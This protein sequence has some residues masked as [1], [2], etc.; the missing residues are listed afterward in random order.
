MQQ[1]RREVPSAY[2][3]VLALPIGGPD[4]RDLRRRAYRPVSLAAACG[5]ETYSALILAETGC[6]HREEKPV[7]WDPGMY[8]MM[9][10]P[11][12]DFR[13]GFASQCMQRFRIDAVGHEGRTDAMS[14]NVG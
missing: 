10:L 5:R 14:G 7:D 13:F 12:Q 1:L 4:L 8:E 9:Q 3:R 2:L 11:Q 6:G